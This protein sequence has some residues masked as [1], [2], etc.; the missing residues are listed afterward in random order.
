MER[1][2]NKASIWLGLCLIIG[3][4]TLGYF[5]QQTA[6]KYRTYELSLIHI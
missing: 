6:V 5:I 1:I 3:L 2:S 4:G